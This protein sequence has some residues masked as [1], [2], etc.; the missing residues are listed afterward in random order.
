V[1]GNLASL[2]VSIMTNQLQT[3]LKENT[4]LTVD[5]ILNI[6]NNFNFIKTK[7]NQILEQEGKVCKHLYFI[8]KGCLRLYQIDKN[9]KHITGYFSFE[10][11]V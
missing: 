11:F 2:E 9:G 1:I 8:T 3:Y 4:K 6:C 10:A 7:R 5:E